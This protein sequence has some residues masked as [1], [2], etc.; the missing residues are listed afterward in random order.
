LNEW[1]EIYD[2]PTP[3]AEID[4]RLYSTQPGTTF[5]TDGLKYYTKGPDT[6][7]IVAEAVAYEL[8][9]RV[10]LPVPEWAWCRHPGTG[11]ILFASRAIRI[12]SAIDEVLRMRVPTDARPFLSECVAFDVWTFNQDRNIGNIVAEPIGGEKSTDVRLYAIDFE[13]AAVLRG[14][15]RII[16]T[17][18]P[19]RSCLPRESLVAHC[20]ELPYP[21]RIC[22]Q[23]AGV[24]EDEI[25]GTFQSVASALAGHTVSWIETASTY[26]RWRAERIDKLVSEVRNA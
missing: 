4:G 25:T 13:K 15:S 12:R 6:R 23:I 7:T 18:L 24:S 19:P 20:K 3:V 14:E 1:I 8:A 26:L 10:G 16:I 21:K 22:A 2:E 9:K 17:T 11:A 5:G